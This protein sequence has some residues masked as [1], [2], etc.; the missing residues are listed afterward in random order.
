MDQVS[1]YI[2]NTSLVKDNKSFVLSYVTEERKQK[3][4]KL[5]SEKDQLLCLGGGYLLKR[6]L[7][8]GEIK[9]TSTRKPYL[10]DGPYF[11]IS[12]SGDYIVLAIHEKRE[13]G[14]D[15]EK[16]DAS[17]LDAIKYVLNEEESTFN[18][19]NTLFEIWSNKESLIKCRGTGIKDIKKVS[20][21]PLEGV[22]E[23]NGSY[24]SK[25]MVYEGYSLSVTLKKKE[26]FEIVI[27]KVESLDK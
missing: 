7:P 5:K 17:R 10:E 1:L 14:V 13:L 8:K 18:E 25:V 24:Y 19:V 4:L 16:I 27:N 6:Y 23:S 11:N 9:V 15:I 2:L 3:A 21:L 12:H 26:P 22:R 20:G